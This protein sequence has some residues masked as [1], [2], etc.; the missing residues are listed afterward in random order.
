MAK[1]QIK[2]AL[3][4]FLFL[5]L[6]FSSFSTFSLALSDAEASLIAR[7]QLL[8]LPENGDLPRDFEYE[9]DVVLTFANERLRKA[10]IALQA[11]KKAIYSDPLNTTGNWVGADVCAY[12]GVFCAPALDDPKLSVVAGVDLN[13][14]DI[15][16]YLPVELGL[17]TDLALFHINSNR[18]C[19]IIPESLSRLTLMFEFDASNNRFVG[20]F[21][22]VVLTW[23]E[24]KYL[25][26]RF[27]DFEGKLPPE[28]FEKDL[29]ALFLNNNRF[30][31][32]IPNTLGKSKVSVVSFANNKFSG[33]IPR[34]I[35]DMGNTLNEI[36][37]IGNNLGGCFPPEIGLLNNVTVFAASSNGFIGT[38]PKSLSGLK[39]VEELDISNNKLTGY[40]PDNV[41]KLPNLANFTFS[42]NYFSGEAQACVPSQKTQDVVLN[43]TSNCLPGRPKQKS[44]KLCFPVVTR[45][46]DCSKNCGGSSHPSPKP[47]PPKS[48]PTPSP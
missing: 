25:D 46:V 47:S 12:N 1:P 33:C 38:L 9:V 11:L 18:F 3:G 41:C 29:D 31:S 42:Y 20:K 26:L 28:L 45:P 44:T 23:P 34:S 22:N 43:D 30:I 35:G 14:A 48:N 10:Y 7:R 4:C 27:N 36:L 21:P 5:S 24:L 16:G 40:V 39:S 32:T 37:F 19:G 2:Q 17:L 8:T 6:L 15:A 13:H